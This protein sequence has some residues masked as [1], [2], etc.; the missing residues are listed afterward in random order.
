MS[1][2]THYR[3]AQVVTAGEDFVI[4]QIPWK[5]AVRGTVVVKVIACGVCHSDAVTKF[6]LMT[7]TPAVLPR[8][9]GH[10][11]VGTVVQVGEGEQRWKVGDRVGS[12]WHG[13]HCSHCLSCRKGDF[14]TCENQN[15]NGVFSDGGYAEYATL[16]TEALAAVPEGLDPFEA[17]PLLCGGLT[18][19]NSLRNMDVHPGDVVAVQGIGGLGH[20]AIQFARQMGFRT[21][22]LSSGS[23]KEALA[24]EL[25]A[26]DYLDGSLVDQAAE[27]Q[28]MG[29]AKVILAT[30]PNPKVMETLVNGLGVGGQ[31]VCLAVA[32]GISVPI[33]P[34]IMK[35][36]SIVGWPSGTAQD[37]E[38]TMEFAKVSQ[39]K[40]K[41]EKFPLEKVNEAF[42]RMMSGDVRFRAVLTME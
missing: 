1:F 26:H 33:I 10:E 21:V 8:T 17:S 42:A 18:T 35:R 3:A 29:G 23:S 27:L 20:L 40:C 7:S 9:P 22:A 30:A 36:L 38:D 15:I 13:G 4:N 6:Q 5:D 12:G 11:I 2:P 37:S 34:M 31:L 41:I 19:F 32:E 24:R 16:H 39:V 25:G 28:K 14:V